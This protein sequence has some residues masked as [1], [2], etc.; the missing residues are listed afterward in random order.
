MHFENHFA[1]RSVE[2]PEELKHPQKFPHLRDTPFA[3]KE[4]EPT[5]AEVEKAISSFKNNRSAGT[6][7]LKTEC[8]KY[9]YSSTLIV[10]LTLLL[11]LIW[12]TLKVPRKWLHSEVTCLFKKGSRLI[13][14]NYRGISIG[15]NM[16]R[17]FCKIIID[18]IQDAYENNISNAQ[19]GFRRNQ[20]TTDRGGGMLVNS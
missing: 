19:F 11:S 3:I 5:E 7:K 16:S 18:R 17:I 12:S 14:S 9:N 6:D 15:T 13:A 2:L 20:S 1:N 8:L 4:D 10:C